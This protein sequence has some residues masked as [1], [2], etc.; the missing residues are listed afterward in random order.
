MKA[1]LLLIAM[2]GLLGACAPTM[3]RVE[4]LDSIPSMY[5]YNESLSFLISRGYTIKTADKDN[6]LITAEFYNTYTRNIYPATIQI[7]PAGSEPRINYNFTFG[8]ASD[9]QKYISAAAANYKASP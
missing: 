7:R 6:F 8:I 9:Y 2:T 5:L 3:T 4:N 1:R